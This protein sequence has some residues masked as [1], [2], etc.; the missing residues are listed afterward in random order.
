MRAGEEGY[1]DLFA[2]GLLILYDMEG[3]YVE[4]MDGYT[5]KGLFSGYAITYLPR[6]IKA[7]YHKSQENHLMCTQED[8]SRQW[9]QRAR[10]VSWDS[11][12]ES[13]D[14]DKRRHPLDERTIRQPGNFINPPAVG[15]SREQAADDRDTA[16]A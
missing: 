7:A 12:I 3:K 9:E 16:D 15:A 5:Q 1:E 11:A 13:A 8:G 14:S 10:A 4:Q 2:E 6:K